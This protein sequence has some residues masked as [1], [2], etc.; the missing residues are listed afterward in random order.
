MISVLKKLLNLICSQHLFCKM[1]TPSLE[2]TM[3][4]TQSWMWS[5]TPLVSALRGQKEVDLQELRPA[6]SNTDQPN[7]LHSEKINKASLS[8]DTYL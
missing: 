2:P 1:E 5:S 3:K 6:W 4:A 8:S 7:S